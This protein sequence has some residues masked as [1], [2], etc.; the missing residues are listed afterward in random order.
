VSDTGTHLI[1]R[2]YVLHRFAYC[3]FD[4]FQFYWTNLNRYLRRDMRYH[5][6]KI[7][8]K[9][10]LIKDDLSVDIWRSKN[11]NDINVTETKPVFSLS[12]FVSLSD[13]HSMQDIEHSII[14]CKSYP[15]SIASS[16]SSGTIK[17]YSMH[18]YANSSLHSGSSSKHERSGQDFLS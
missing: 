15:H 17:S 3:L 9:V 7:Q 4:D 2:V 10:A 18:S 16:D 1:Q 13:C 6:S 12:K 11:E 8:C 5:L 14:S